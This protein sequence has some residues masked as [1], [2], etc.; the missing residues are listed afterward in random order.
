MLEDYDVVIYGG[1][2]YASGILGVE[3][4]TKTPCKNLV[5]FTVGLADSTITDYSLILDKNLPS[6]IRKNIKVF[7]FRGGIDY[8]N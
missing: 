2:L 3:R 4:V 8:K 6:E 1:G 5:L 7:H